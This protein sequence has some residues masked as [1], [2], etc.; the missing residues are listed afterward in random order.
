M[1]AL[2]PLA[3]DGP[4]KPPPSDAWPIGDA[5]R[6]LDGS[7]LWGWTHYL[8]ESGQAGDVSKLTALVK[9]TQDRG[10]HD[11]VWAA[12]WARI[13]RPR[14]AGAALRAERVPNPVRRAA[15]SG[16]TNTRRSRHYCEQAAPR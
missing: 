9:A 6:Q 8:V 15:R 1:K 11:Q 5:A 16:M 3:K 12:V 14:E 13:E 10:V 4:T 7:A 2:P